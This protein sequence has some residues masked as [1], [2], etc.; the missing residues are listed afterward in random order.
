MLLHRDS[1]NYLI[2]LGTEKLLQDVVVSRHLLEAL[3]SEPRAVAGAVGPVVGVPSAMV[4]VA[5]SQRLARLCLDQSYDFRATVAPVWPFESFERAVGSDMARSILFE[6]WS[7]LITNSWLFSKTRE[8]FDKMV[9][10]G[11]SAIHLSRERFDS[12]VRKTL[13]KDPSE[14]M[15]GSD[16]T[17]AAAKWVAVG[18]PA[19]LS[20]V[21]PISAATSSAAAG[22]FLMYDP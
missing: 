1:A 15:T 13:K 4:D 21:E 22:Y 10:A 9:E 8:A 17:R 14:P 18:G 20:L 5:T 11:G 7:F 6:E 2:A 16:R 12:V 19:I 3:L